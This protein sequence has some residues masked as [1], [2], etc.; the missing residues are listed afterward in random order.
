M[1]KGLG[2]FEKCRPFILTT[3]LETSLLLEP[4]TRLV[5][6]LVDSLLAARRPY[7]DRLAVAGKGRAL[8]YRS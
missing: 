2:D 3:M 4:G 6:I 7:G 8:A 5:E 1:E